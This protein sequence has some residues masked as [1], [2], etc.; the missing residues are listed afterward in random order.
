MDY[1]K[2]FNLE[3][4]PFS[5]TPDPDFFYSSSRHAECLQKLEIAIRLRR[6]L[7]IV[8]GEVGTGKTTL[9]RQLIQTLSNDESMEVHLVLDPGFEQTGDFA[10]AV[11]EMLTGR[12]KAR[13]CSTF[14]QHKEMIK[15]HLFAAGVDQGK[16][17]VL[18]LDEGQ[19]LPSGCVEFLRELLNYETND[20]KLLQIVI[21]AQNEI[22]D[23]LYAHSNF[24]DRA[25]LY[26]HLQPLNRKE[27]A[28]LISH[29]LQKAGKQPDNRSGP[30]FTRRAL[31]RIYRI[32]RGYPRS[33]IHLGHNILLLLLI[34]GGTRVS[35]AVVARAAAGLPAVK[36]TPPAGSGH[37]AVWI[38]A[39]GLLLAAAVVT[40]YAQWPVSGESEN[41]NK[42]SAE[43]P[44]PTA[45]TQK[46]AA[47]NHKIKRESDPPQ[48][49]KPAN[50]GQV[51]INQNEKLWNMLNRI[52][53]ICSP[54]L[55]EK[56]QK[57]N[58]DL[59]NPDRISP[60][61]KIILPV[62]KS[63]PVESGQQYWIAWKKSG[64][65]NRVYQF[66]FDNGSKK[67]RVLSYW[68]PSSGLEHAA[69]D[70]RCYARYADAKKALAAAGK[71]SLPRPVIVDLSGDEIRLFSGFQNS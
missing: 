62:I 17:I 1:Y 43:K 39:A 24:A 37:R 5:N 40:A 34:K 26:H 23:L 69:V 19:K 67:L 36:K 63:R 22:M 18:I 50:L 33:I 51:R 59:D 41:K 47:A 57:A 53:G 12:E 42:A 32:S 15:N 68:D 65:L 8:R 48:P 10:A 21:F 13:S 6:G 60:G 29:R 38:S 3:K 30:H 7:C 16:T 58:P 64:D 44:A 52:Y 27:T 20:Y 49:E 4:E 55:V 56:I 28:Q 66:I 71:A 61:Q 9:C 2:L 31:A 54:E 70:G 14:A 11:N 45:V 35:P 46:T 25:A